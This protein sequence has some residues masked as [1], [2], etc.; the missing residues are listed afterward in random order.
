[1]VCRPQARVQPEAKEVKW[2]QEG[3]LST[4]CHKVITKVPN[5]EVKKASTAVSSMQISG[6]GLP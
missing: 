5:D 1:M 3:V 4:L 2:C 6:K